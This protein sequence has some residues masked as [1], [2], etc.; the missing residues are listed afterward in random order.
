VARRI[1]Q[2]R[3]DLV[4]NIGNEYMTRNLMG[5]LAQ[6]YHRTALNAPKRHFLTRLVRDL[7]E[8]ALNEI[9][10]CHYTVPLNTSN[11]NGFVFPGEYMGQYGVYDAVKHVYKN[12]ESLKHLVHEDH[13]LTNQRYFATEMERGIE[14]LK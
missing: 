3:P 5:D 4:L 12:N 1:Y 6:M 9:D 8:D 13:L 14:N 10:F 11:P 7:K 2:S